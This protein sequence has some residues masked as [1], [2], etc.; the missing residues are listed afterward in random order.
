MKET[1]RC[2]EITF[3]RDLDG[4]VRVVGESRERGVITLLYSPSPEKKM[5]LNKA[6]RFVHLTL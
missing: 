4:V 2:E 3:I 5:S 6:T 1:I